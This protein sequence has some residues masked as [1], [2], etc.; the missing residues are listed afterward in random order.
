MSRIYDY[1]YRSEGMYPEKRYGQ[2]YLF[3][4]GA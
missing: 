4:E 1:T 2:T 3:D